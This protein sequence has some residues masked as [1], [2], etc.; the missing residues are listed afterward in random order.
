MAHKKNFLYRA[1]LCVLAVYLGSCS[2]ELP[3]K[4][5]VKGS[6]SL[7]LPLGA[8]Q[9]PKEG[10]KLINIQDLRDTL[11]E[12]MAIYDY[13]DR[14]TQ[15]FLVHYRKDLEPFKFD[16]ETYNFEIAPIA[17]IQEQVEIPDFE[18]ICEDFTISCTG[19][20]NTAGITVPGGFSFD[21]PI[22]GGGDLSD[23]SGGSI[24]VRFKKA[25]LGGY[26]DLDPSSS[27]GMTLDLSDV[28][29]TLSS[30]ASPADTTTL[31]TPTQ[32]GAVYRFPLNNVS[33][34]QD[35]EAAL[36]GTA[37]IVTS[38]NYTSGDSINVG[39]DVKVDG[40]ELVG[41]T[42]AVQEETEERIID[43]P[44]PDGV[45]KITFRK[46]GAT[47]DIG[48]ENGLGFTVD[49][50]Q[51][52]VALDFYEADKETLETSP[53][54]TP[55]FSKS[56][57]I[58]F[59]NGFSGGN[60]QFVGFDSLELPPPMD[61]TGSLSDIKSAKVTVTVNPQ[62]G[63]NDRELIIRGITSGSTITLEA[64]GEPTFEIDRV[65]LN[66]NDFITEE[67][68]AS[69]FPGDGEKGLN[70]SDFTGDLEENIDIADLAFDEIIFNI[71]LN[72][73]GGDIN[74]WATEPRL[75][76]TAVDKAEGGSTIPITEDTGGK[77]G[78]VV[79][80]GAETPDIE[81]PGFDEAQGEF[82]GI[83]PTGHFTTGKLADILNARPGDLHVKYRFGFDQPYTFV[84]PEDY[85][86]AGHILEKTISAELL[87]EVPVK[88][89]LY[90]KKDENGGELDY[91]SLEY[92]FEGEEDLLGRKPGE[93][94]PYA[95]YTQY[96]DTASVELGYENT[97]GLD[98]VT[99]VLGGRDSDFEKK[100][101]P[102]EERGTIDLTLR[103]DEIPNPF[104]PQVEVRVPARY[105]PKEPGGRRYGLVELKRG[106][107]E[108]PAGLN[109]FAIRVKARTYIDQ[110]ISF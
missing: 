32:I 84:F 55:A 54:Q 73:L 79:G 29:L 30:Y 88:L 98:G 63:G 3:E 34:F 85:I 28:T 87:I 74:I 31:S 69:S 36:G 89:M 20:V 59:G 65:V 78:Q 66:L 92:K 100:L 86:T 23:S 93:E 38:T 12:E 101:G 96:L 10:E 16:T 25:V 46:I 108:A 76:L 37:H 17:Q 81:L 48:G 64:G 109:A 4:I 60:D 40:V 56:I 18:D 24:D 103:G 22:S 70:F 44:L 15:T 52:Q 77:E 42:M 90:A 13:I 51:F 68:R 62:E 95:D 21:V 110:D 6:P 33:V 19:T 11:G 107:A 1:C 99:L 27:S 41:V 102:L 67:Q 8:Y 45:E 72:G 47:L 75:S 105:G 7:D 43:L 50:L 104:I 80:S 71:Y 49:N 14:E 35:T 97:L 5:S 83:I 57:D 39:V 106:T 2:F 61:Y 9:Y 58:T 91:G 82:S 94:D 26:L 53:P